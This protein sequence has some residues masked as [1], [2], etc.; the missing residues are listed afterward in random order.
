[1]SFTKK[2]KMLFTIQQPEDNDVFTKEAI[3]LALMETN[4]DSTEINNVQKEVNRVKGIFYVALLL[5]VEAKLHKI[6]L[7]PYL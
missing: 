1:M 4:I 5:F 6:Y 2:K 3:S 7:L